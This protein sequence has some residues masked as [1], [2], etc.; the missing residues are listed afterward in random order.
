LLKLLKSIDQGILLEN[1]KNLTRHD[2]GKT[3]KS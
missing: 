1:V 3:L 2:K